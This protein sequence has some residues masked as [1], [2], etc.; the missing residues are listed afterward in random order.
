MNFKM[1]IIIKE[2]SITQELNAYIQKLNYEMEAFKSI[3]ITIIRGQG[4]FTYNKENYDYYMAKF[5]E[6]NMEYRLAMNELV[7]GY[8]DEIEDKSLV[9][10][11][12]DFI[13]CLV[14]FV[15]NER[16]GNSCP[17]K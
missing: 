16:S 6:S 2:V 5:Q 17:Q 10:V 3:S 9:D 1:K 4:E 7:T 14:R 8:A 12:V 11:E 13:N 15:K